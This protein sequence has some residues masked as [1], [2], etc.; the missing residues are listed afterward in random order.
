MYV[1]RLGSP[2]ERFASRVRSYCE[3]NLVEEKRIRGDGI[4]SGPIFYRS[5]YLV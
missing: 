1:W 2:T 3:D 5:C 4:L